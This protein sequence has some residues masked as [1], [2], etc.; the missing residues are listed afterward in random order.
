MNQVF[1]HGNIQIFNFSLYSCLFLKHR[2]VHL[3]ELQTK[4]VLE[5]HEILLLKWFHFLGWG[6]NYSDHISLSWI[7]LVQLDYLIIIA[8][9]LREFVLSFSHNLKDLK[10]EK[11]DFNAHSI[12]YKNKGQDR[13]YNCLIQRFFWPWKEL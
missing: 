1:R 9:S 6:S 3:K 10:K 11:K 5:T 2:T 12:V 7:I 13:F 8:I 4:I